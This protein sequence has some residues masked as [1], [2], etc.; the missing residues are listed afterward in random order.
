MFSSNSFVQWTVLGSLIGER[1]TKWFKPP[2][3]T[4]F[5]CKESAAS[6]HAKL[7]FHFQNNL[8]LIAPCPYQSSQ[9]KLVYLELL[10][11]V[12]GL[13]SNDVLL[14]AFTSESWNV[15]DKL[16][17]SWCLSV[18]SAYVQ[19]TLPSLPWFMTQILEN[20]PR[21]TN[22]GPFFVS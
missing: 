20:W 5:T 3:P 21:L 13:E 22:Q 19:T 6:L 17:W 12:H 4:G 11:L 7:F 1:I 8:I 14:S 16:P 2:V 9:Q 15:W 18:L 10:A